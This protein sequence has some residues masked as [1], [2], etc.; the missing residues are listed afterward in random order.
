MRWEVNNS[1]AFVNCADYTGPELP[2]VLGRKEVQV[3]V[4]RNLPVNAVVVKAR[5]V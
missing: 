4:A 3:L 1:L 2:P 5:E